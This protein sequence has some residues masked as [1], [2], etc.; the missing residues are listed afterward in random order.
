MV[1]NATVDLAPVNK[2]LK[3]PSGERP[4]KHWKKITIS[5]IQ[6]QAGGSWR[7]TATIEGGGKMTIYVNNLPEKIR[8]YVQSVSDLDAKI[9]NLEGQ[10]AEEKTNAPT[11]HIR[12]KGRV[13]RQAVDAQKQKTGADQTELSSLRNQYQEMTA[14]ASEKAETL[15]M[16]TGRN[17][18]SSQI[19]DCGKP[20][21]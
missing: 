18:G 21:P 14:K 12:V 5:E 8:T 4:L 10:V 9:K 15:A 20:V 17:Y 1:G 3:S 16:F 7:C 2:W 11:G 6:E 13:A 19:W